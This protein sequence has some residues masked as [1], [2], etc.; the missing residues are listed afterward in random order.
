MATSSSSSSLRDRGSL[1][2][3]SYAS[4]DLT[5]ITDEKL[6]PSLFDA[7]CTFNSDLVN[8]DDV[9]VAP[10]PDHEGPDPMFLS[11]WRFSAARLVGLTAVVP[12]LFALFLCRYQLGELMVRWG[13]DEALTLT[14][15]LISFGFLSTGIIGC[16]E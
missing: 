10:V 15:L 16:C 2:P 8:S 9:F 13:N 3:L 7:E 4:T 6:S 1:S 14:P 11:A 12:E 5:D